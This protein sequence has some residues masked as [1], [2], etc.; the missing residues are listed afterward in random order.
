M[1]QVA[2]PSPTIKSCITSKN[3]WSMMYASASY[4]QMASAKTSAEAYDITVKR[5]IILDPAPTT[6]H[7]MASLTT[8]KELCRRHIAGLCTNG[9]QCKYSH[10]PAPSVKGAPHRLFQNPMSR[11]HLLIRRTMER[12][13]WAKHLT[14]HPSR[15]TLSS[16][17]TT[18]HL[19]DTL[20]AN[21]LTPTQLDIHSTSSHPSGHYSPLILM[22][23]QLEIQTTSMVVQVFLI[24]SDSMCWNNTATFVGLEEQLDIWCQC[25]QRSTTWIH[26]LSSRILN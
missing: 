18:V 19:S 5:L 4:L 26:F 10:A 15:N 11:V 22:D 24:L 16:P 2:S 6:A 8:N 1:L 9:T 12:L 25:I 13:A 21:P 17:K 14:N 3:N 20:V 7:K 23:G